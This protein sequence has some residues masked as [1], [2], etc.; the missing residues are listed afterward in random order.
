MVALL[1]AQEFIDRNAQRLAL[2]VVQRDV[3]GTDGGLQD[4]PAL[5]ILRPIHFLPQR[6]GQERIAATQEFGIM[7][8]RANNRFFPA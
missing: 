7:F 8:D 6:P 2:E 1:A 5:K 4:A 3:D